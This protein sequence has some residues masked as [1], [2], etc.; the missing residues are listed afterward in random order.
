MKI[1]SLGCVLALL[2][3]GAG[4]AVAHHSPAV[5]DRSRTMT[6]EGVVTQF[7]WSNPHSWI[8]IDVTNDD[9]E[10]QNWTIE[11]NPATLLARGGWRRNSVQPGDSVSVLVHPLRRPDERGGQFVSITLPDGQVLGEVPAVLGA[12]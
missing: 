9:G 4:S 8:H 11:M 7:S 1:S 3:A 2:A 6:L 5:F 12:R 10:V